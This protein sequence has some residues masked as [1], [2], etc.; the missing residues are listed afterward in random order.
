MGESALLGIFNV[1]ELLWSDLHVYQHNWA[2]RW[3]SIHYSFEV[4]IW[5]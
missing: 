4:F 2:C 5:F 3:P 1:N